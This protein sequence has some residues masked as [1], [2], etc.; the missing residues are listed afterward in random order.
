MRFRESYAVTQLNGTKSNARFLLHHMGTGFVSGSKQM[1]C[2]PIAKKNGVD[3]RMFW[4]GLCRLAGLWGPMSEGGDHKERLTTTSIFFFILLR[5]ED[6][7]R[8]SGLGLADKGEMQGDTEPKC[9]DYIVRR[10]WDENVLETIVAI[11]T[12]S[13]D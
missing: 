2:E 13:I 4:Y 1:S 7:L 9:W 12:Y 6:R 5:A 11:L 3:V 8:I 10:A